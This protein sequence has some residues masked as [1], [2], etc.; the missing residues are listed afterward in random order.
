MLHRAHYTHIRSLYH[1]RL[2][3]NTFTSFSCLFTGFFQ[4]E[5]Q[6]AVSFSTET[7]LLLQLQLYI[8]LGRITS[9]SQASKI[10]FE[11]W[12]SV[13]SVWSPLL[14]H[15]FWR[16]WTAKDCTCSNSKGPKPGSCGPSAVQQSQTNPIQVFLHVAKLR[17]GLVIGCVGWTKWERAQST[18]LFRCWWPKCP[19]SIHTGMVSQVV[20]NPPHQKSTSLTFTKSTTLKYIYIYILKER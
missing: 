15:W 19:E 14:C 10:K 4:E 8:F 16:C 20:C 2:Q 12:R 7:S 17:V 3:W 18:V 6:T 9:T 13:F 11:V 1:P 5:V